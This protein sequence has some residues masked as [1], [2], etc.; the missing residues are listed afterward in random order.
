M[1]CCGLQS[2]FAR[3]MLGVADTRLHRRVAARTV[4]IHMV[5]ELDSILRA[6]GWGYYPTAGGT[7][8]GFTVDNVELVVTS[9]HTAGVGRLRSAG[10]F[11][12]PGS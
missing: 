11:L 3:P 9:R 6:S 2:P 10:V 7:L 8:E 4:G 12:G 5:R 1:S